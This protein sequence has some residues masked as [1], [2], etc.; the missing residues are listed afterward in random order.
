YRRELDAQPGVGGGERGS[1]HV[2]QDDEIGVLA[3]QPQ[4]V[5]RVGERRPVRHRL[6]QRR[7][8][9]VADLCAEFGAELPEAAR[10]YVRVEIGWILVLGRHFV[11]RVGGKQLFVGQG[12]SAP[13]RPRAEHGS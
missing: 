1:V 10:E 12:Q 5:G 6:R 7:R 11:G 8:V 13:P 2:R 3:Q 9:L 4:R